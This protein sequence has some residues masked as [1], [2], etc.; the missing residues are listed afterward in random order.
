MS[1][2]ELKQIVDG[3]T[4]EERRFLREYLADQYPEDT[5]FD[6][7]DLSR[8]MKDIDEGKFV[9]WNQLIAAHERLKAEGR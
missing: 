2:A 7:A 3:S 1:V 9:T 6:P 5:T 8:R 4:A